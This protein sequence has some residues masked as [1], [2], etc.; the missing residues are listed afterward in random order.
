MSQHIPSIQDVAT[1][2]GC[3]SFSVITPGDAVYKE[4][5]NKQFY[6]PAE[7]TALITRRQIRHCTHLIHAL[8]LSLESTAYTP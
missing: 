8:L 1:Y 4:G 2:H 3:I 6:K 5:F 7:K